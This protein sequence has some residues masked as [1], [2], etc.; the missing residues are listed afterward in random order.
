MYCE[1]FVKKGKKE[2][3]C[4][5]C[6]EII[7]TGESSW[8]VPGENFETNYHFHEKCYKK[9]TKKYKEMEDYRKSKKD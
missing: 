6:G 8:N 5:E 3:W 1:K 9:I 4:Y 2:K 7:K